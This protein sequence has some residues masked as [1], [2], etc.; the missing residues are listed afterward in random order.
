MVPL[1]TTPDLNTKLTQLMLS[2]EKDILKFCC[3][4]LQDISL[5][6]DATQETFF[7][8]YK[9]LTN[10]RGDAA[11]K[12]WLMRIAVNTCR[13]IRRAAWYRFVDRRVTLNHL[14][15]PAAPSKEENVL[16]AL[17]VMRLPSKEREAVLLRHYFG[18]TIKEAAEVL[19]VSGAAVSKRL[20][21][22]HQR[23]SVVRKGEANDV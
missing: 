7:K 19:H 3:I 11:E 2:Y 17:E 22:A 9:A 14:P 15:E 8:A 21:R 20:G 10:F 12:T 1:H 5:A 16:L 18:M 4:Y 6:E 13:D 23:L